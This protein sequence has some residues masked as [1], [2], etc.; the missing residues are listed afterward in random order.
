MA[1]LL[2]RAINIFLIIASYSII[3]YAVVSW[4]PFRNDSIVIKLLKWFVEPLIEP[5]RYIIKYSI[6]SDTRGRIEFAPIISYLILNTL[7]NN[8]MLFIQ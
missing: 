2:L 7:H 1:M 3:I 8:I 4:L 5:V 6:F